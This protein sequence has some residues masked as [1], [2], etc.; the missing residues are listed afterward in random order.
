[1]KLSIHNIVSKI[2]QV[3]Q[4][5]KVIVYKLLQNICGQ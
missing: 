2:T 4:K 1:M 5:N 3:Y